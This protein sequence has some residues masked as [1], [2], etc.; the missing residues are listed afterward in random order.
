[1]TTR[2]QDCPR[3]SNLIRGSRSLGWSS[4]G[5]TRTQTHTAGAVDEH[6][7]PLG[8]LEVGAS[9]RELERLG[10]W[11]RAFDGPR[12]FAIEGAKGSG[13]LLSR[14]FLALDED[15][16][17]IPTHL[18]ADG[19]RSSRSRGKDDP[20]DAITIARIAL[21]EPGLPRLRESHLE[22]D[23]KLLVDARDQIVAEGTR[24][25]NRL[26][27]LLLALAPGYRTETGALS[28]R[29]GLLAAGRLARQARATDPIRARIALGP[30]RRLRQVETE[31][32]EL[33]A[34]IRSLVEASQSNR[35]LA[36]CGVGPIVAAKILGETHDIGLF[37][38]AAAFAAHAGAAPL[39]P[40]SGTVH[41]HRLNRGGNRQLNRALFTIAM[42]QA[43]WDP[44]G[45]AYLA[46][47]RAEGKRPAEARRCSMRHL[48]NVVYRAMVADA[49]ARGARPV[50]AA[51]HCG[52]RTARASS[53]SSG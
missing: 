39:P 6:G 9:T 27:A 29:R 14:R 30:I 5:S 43:R 38:S 44:Q 47:K 15:V 13:L 17:D 8:T 24:V 51:W 21:R 40:S 28:N 33:E 41:R 22:A 34:E 4:S 23:L 19:R 18:T 3:P 12:L 37:P 49:V 52:A 50:E 1:V 10:A 35:L 32:G 7:R 26:H 11:T 46:R 31:A 48:A 25:R 45:I 42:V 36:V 53:A 20:S 16:V 2:R